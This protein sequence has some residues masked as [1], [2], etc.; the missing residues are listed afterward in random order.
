MKQDTVADLMDRV[1]RLGDYQSTVGQQA[2]ISVGAGTGTQGQQLGSYTDGNFY[3]SDVTLLQFLDFSYN[4]AYEHLSDADEDWQAERWYPALTGSVSI[5]QLP[6][7][8]YKLRCVEVQDPIPNAGWRVLPHATADDDLMFSNGDSVIAY[9]LLDN[10]IELVPTP[11]AWAAQSGSLRVT[12][13]PEAPT[14]SSSLQVVDTD[15][16]L[17]DLAVFKATMLCRIRED[18][19]YADIQLM[20]QGRLDRSVNSLK[21]RDRASPRRLRDP[22]NSSS[23]GFPY[24]RM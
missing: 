14:L 5:Y 22:R 1:R 16:G 10:N 21:R 20:W 15:A 24:R 9:R 6:A 3:I 11:A 7:D 23:P 12:Y 13:V 19:P 8:H 4:E 17:G 18:R 2:G